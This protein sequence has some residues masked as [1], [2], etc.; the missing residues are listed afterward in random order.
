MELYALARLLRAEYSV[1]G[2]RASG[3]EPGEAVHQRIEDM[4]RAY[5]AAIREIQAHGPYVIAGYSM[6]GLVAYEM[7][8]HLIAEG[9]RV[10]LLVLLDTGVHERYWPA[11]AWFEHCKRRLVHHAQRM[12]RLA[13]SELAP[14]FAHVTGA[15]LKRVGRATGFAATI[16]TAG[17]LLPETLR[18]QRRAGLLAFAAYRPR[19][20]ALPITL[21]CSEVDASNLCDPRRVWRKLTPALTIYDVPGSHM[22]MIRPPHLPVLAARLSCCVNAARAAL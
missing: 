19:A 2:I 11:D 10:A 22:T 12:R 15:L 14:A 1:Y 6:G 21:L 8:Q 16:D 9:E 3:S 17:P 4:G 7:A 5:L 13:W 20:S 18:R